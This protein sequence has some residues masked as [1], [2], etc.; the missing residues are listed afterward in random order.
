VFVALVELNV[1]FAPDPEPD[2]AIEA[3][4]SSKPARSSVVLLAMETAD[5]LEIRFAA[6]SAIAP[7]DNVV[8][9]VYVLSPD[10]VSVPVPCF[11]MPSDEPDIAP[12]IVP[13]PL[14][15]TPMV[16][17]DPSVTLP[18]AL[19]AAEKYSAP[20]EDV[21]PLSVS[22]SLTMTAAAISSVAPVFTVVV[23]RV[24]TPPVVDSPSA[25]ALVIFTAPCE[26][27]VAPV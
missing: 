1:T 8:V 24:V 2:V 27:V 9:P 6:P 25:R 15:T 17:F 14:L 12:E 16:E 11:V 19:P 7:A 3:T 21:V 10:S 22:G 18:A 13:E 20:L 23:P 26:I 5:E 4:V